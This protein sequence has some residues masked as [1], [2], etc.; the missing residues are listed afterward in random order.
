M[1]LNLCEKYDLSVKILMIAIFNIKSF[2]IVKLVKLSLLF[3]Y[4]FLGQIQDIQKLNK[5]VLLKTKLL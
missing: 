4:I 1:V 3:S 5:V 2:E